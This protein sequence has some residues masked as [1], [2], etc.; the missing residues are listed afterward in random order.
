M[1][2]QVS[3]YQV[4]KKSIKILVYIDSI[5]IPAHFKIYGHFMSLSS[6]LP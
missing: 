1:M 2:C 4:L 3:E 5:R 6:A